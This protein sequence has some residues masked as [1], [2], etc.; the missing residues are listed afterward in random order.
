MRY[1]IYIAYNGTNYHG[2]QIQPNA[3]TVQETVG[4]AMS[5]VLGSNVEITGAGRTDT[6]VHARTMTAHFDLTKRIDEANLVKRLNSL[7]PADI[8]VYKIV[9]VIP[10][11]HARFSALSRTYEYLL[12]FDKNPFLKGLAYR[13]YRKLD[14]E[15]MNT[16]AAKMLEY[17]DFTSFSK[18]HT[19]TRTNNCK[20][21]IAKWEQRGDIW[22]FTIKA[23]RFLRDM[24]RATVGTL[25]LVGEYSIDTEG[26]M[27]VI[28]AK[29]RQKAGQS[30]DACGLYLS[31]IE[32]DKNIFL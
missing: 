21:L 28:E 24:V 6:G 15:V 27:S 10:E 14:F 12:Y 25:I 22:V 20:V 18:L 19:D 4:Q 29:D 17:T 1:F 3:V 32:Y 5:V 2:W 30:I 8:A 13:H 16:A 26:F 23:D 11:A 7:L 9:E 31:D